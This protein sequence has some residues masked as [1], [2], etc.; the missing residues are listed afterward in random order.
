MQQ[1]GADFDHMV[2]ATYYVTDNASS[3]LLGTIREELY[4][5]RRPPAASKALVKG[6]GKNGHSLML[7]MIAA[8]PK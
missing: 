7:E 2:K 6:V 8:V 3:R 4:N 5:P 1:V